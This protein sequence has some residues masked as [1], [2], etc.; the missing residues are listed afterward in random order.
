[1]SSQLWL[2]FLLPFPLSC[3]LMEQLPSGC[4]L[5]SGRGRT[6]G[7][8]RKLPLK[9]LAETDHISLLKGSH[10]TTLVPLSTGM[11]YAAER[12][13]IHC[14]CSNPPQSSWK[15]VVK[16]KDAFDSVS[17]SSMWLLLPDLMKRLAIDQCFW[18]QVELASNRLRSREDKSW[19][20]KQN[21]MFNRNNIIKN[22]IKH[23]FR[24]WRK[25]IWFLN[26]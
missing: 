14:S 3:T 17:R 20:A 25:K 13:L 2:C 10:M 9:V 5:V 6:D 21:W 12:E 24:A 18:W 11:Y 7:V 19:K 26:L 8:I 22:K 4:L 16:Q 23:I 15:V 1:M